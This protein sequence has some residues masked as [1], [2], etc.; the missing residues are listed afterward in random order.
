MAKSKRFNMWSFS[1]EIVSRVAQG[2]TVVMRTQGEGDTVR[3]LGRNRGLNIDGPS[4][5]D[6]DGYVVVTYRIATA[7]DI[8]LQ[9]A[10]SSTARG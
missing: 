4:W 5:Y 6:D 7:E 9:E 8:A 1:Q 3:Y 2:E 10:W